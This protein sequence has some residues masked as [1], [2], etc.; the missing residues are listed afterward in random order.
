MTPRRIHPALCLPIVAGWMALSLCLPAVAEAQC[1]MDTPSGYRGMRGASRI[2]PYSSRSECESVN[3][4]YFSGRGSCSCSGEGGSAGGGF[5]MPGGG[6]PELMMMQMFMQFGFDLLGKQM[7]CTFNPDCDAN[8]QQRR[9]QEQQRQLQEQER[10][11]REALQ[12]AAE[13]ERRRKEAERRDRF[14]QTRQKL[15]G[16]MRLQPGSGDLQPRNLGLETRETAAGL[17]ARTLGARDLGA[18]SLRAPLASTSC[19]AFLLRKADEAALRGDLQEASFLSSEAAALM[20]GEKVTTAVECPPPPAVPEIGEGVAI[21]TEENR[22]FREQ[23]EQGLKQR[24]RFMSLM[25]KR[26][27]DQGAKYR[28]AAEEL[29][30]AEERKEQAEAELEAARAEKARLEAQLAQAPPAPSPQ[31]TQPPVAPAASDPAAHSALAEALA[32]MQAAEAAYAGAES[33][34]Q[35]SLANKTDLE[36]QMQQTRSLFDDAQKNPAG[37]DQALKTLEPGN[38]EAK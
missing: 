13:E 28:Q 21:E 10:L 5:A 35:T 19:G 4:Q 6:D 12:R 25:Y 26:V 31:T 1:Y 2:G 14:E 24:S 23:F 17:Q 16:D 36:K 11:Q 30:Q 3:S 20:S 33:D 22:R 37:M 38:K 18:T 29:R 7:E 32:A 34:L 15:L 8:V 9:L 27:A